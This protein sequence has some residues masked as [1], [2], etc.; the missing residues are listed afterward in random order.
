MAK[1][2]PPCSLKP[3]GVPSLRLRLIVIIDMVTVCSFDCRTGRQ[4][5]L[6]PRSLAPHK[7]TRHCQDPPA[8]PTRQICSEQ[9]TGCS[10]MLNSRQKTL[11]REPKVMA[12]KHHKINADCSSPLVILISKTKIASKSSKKVSLKVAY[13]VIIYPVMKITTYKISSIKIIFMVKKHIVYLFTR[14]LIYLT[15]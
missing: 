1:S 15:T 9:T 4:I 6:R 13:S 14:S 12:R 7:T 10:A 3:H 2:L 11:R 5:K 8:C